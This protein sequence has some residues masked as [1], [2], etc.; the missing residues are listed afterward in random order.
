LDGKPTEIN[1]IP[2][3]KLGYEKKT[4]PALRKLARHEPESKKRKQEESG[5][6]I[7]SGDT[8]STSSGHKTE[9]KKFVSIHLIYSDYLKNR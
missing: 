2:Q 7:Y 9:H 6:G 4:T 3:L 8:V 5:A 1:P